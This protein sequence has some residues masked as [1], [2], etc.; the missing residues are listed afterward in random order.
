M[1]NTSEKKDT[2]PTDR[3]NEQKKIEDEMI[4]ISAPFFF[5]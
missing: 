3:D 2:L 1:K 5:E 4:D